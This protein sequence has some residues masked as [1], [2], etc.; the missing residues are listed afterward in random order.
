MKKRDVLNLIKYYVD[1]DDKSFR[2]EAMNIANKFDE[3]GDYEL[4]EYVRALLSNTNTFSPQG[5][6]LDKNFLEKIELTNTPLP[7]PDV[8]SD[9]II[10][11]INAI[12]HNIGVNKFLFEGSPGTGKTESVKHISRILEREL[13]QVNFN[14]L[15]DSK[16]GKT[17]KNITDVFNEINNVN[18]KDRI[19]ILFDE[20]DVIAL[21]RLN[22]N[23]L[24][25]MGRVTSTILKEFDRLDSN[26]VIIAT[27]NLF[28]N[29]DKALIR[30]F[31]AIINFDRYSKKD[32]LEVSENV[33]NSFL[34][35][36][37]KALRN[38]RLFRKIVLS[39]DP[40]PYPG[41]M[42]NLI[43]S[44]L[45]FSDPNDPSDYLKK[46]YLRGNEVSEFDLIKLK[47]LGFTLREIETLTNISR[48][49]LSREF[50]AV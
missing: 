23:D 1:E 19:I 20:I 27:T 2:L 24:R 29:F 26:I 36:F 16:L 35:H 3:M 33:L 31:D 50:K 17:S 39:F 25:E 44:S 46:L 30:R 14:N 9:D 12:N 8:I 38:I 48:S 18:A 47:D 49:S 45:A 32:L 21:D 22:S 41:T 40:I 6:N 34:E 42:K 11:V 13:Y 43:K 4:S 37:P 15:V 5:I 7:L 10:G 28:K